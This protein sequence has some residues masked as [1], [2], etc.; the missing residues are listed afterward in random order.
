MYVSHTPQIDWLEA[1]LAAA[2]EEEQGRIGRWLERAVM[3]HDKLLLD[4]G[5]GHTTQDAPDGLP[6]VPVFTRW[7]EQIHVFLS[8]FCQAG[9]NTWRQLR[10]VR[11]K[12][13]PAKGRVVFTKE[14]RKCEIRR[15]R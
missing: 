9:A 2:P 10:G 4:N 3:E 1:A 8:A 11:E 12:P 15:Q 13:V 14:W 6:E 5:L 7:C